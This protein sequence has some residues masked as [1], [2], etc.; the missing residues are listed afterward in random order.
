MHGYED[1]SF[2]VEDAGTR[3]RNVRLVRLTKLKRLATRYGRTDW[4]AKADEEIDYLKTGGFDEGLDA[5]DDDIA[6]AFM[7]VGQQSSI[8]SQEGRDNSLK[9][10]TW[11]LPQQ[12]HAAVLTIKGLN[13]RYPDWTENPPKKIDLKPIL[14]QATFREV[15]NAQ[16][17]ITKLK[18]IGT[19][20]HAAENIRPGLELILKGEFR[21]DLHDDAKRLLKL[22]VQT[23]QKN[24][25]KQK[26][27][28]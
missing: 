26:R 11:T 20:D 28:A 4:V 25:R 27:R 7:M 8:I 10:R 12:C 5:L 17:Q 9:I 3:E 14:E 21:P 19:P 23:P 24:P 16:G 13:T 2:E 1:G 22:L 6:D 18:G 15:V